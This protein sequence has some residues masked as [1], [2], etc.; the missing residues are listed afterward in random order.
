MT[1]RPFFVFNV[2]IAALTFGLFFGVTPTLRAET[3][4]PASSATAA[5][6]S[7][8]QALVT[9]EVTF[10]AYDFSQPWNDPTR[11]I[12]KH[13]VATGP[14]EL[15]TTAQ[16]LSTQTLVRLQR[17][18]RG[19]WVNARVTWIDLQANLALITCDDAAFW[20]GIT[21]VS[22]AEIVPPG[23]DFSLVSWR[24]GN[25]ETK[26]VEFSKF[27]V[28]TGRLGLAGQLTLEIDSDLP[29]LGWTELLVRDGQ[30]MG[31]TSWAG[32]R[33][34]GVIPAPFIRQVLAARR[35][36][37]YFDFT[38]QTAENPDLAKELKLPGDPRGVIATVPLRKTPQV[39][40]LRERDLILEIDGFTIGAEGDYHDP[41]Y[42]YL[43]LE[44]L[45]TRGHFAGDVIPIKVWREGRELTVEHTL[46]AA[47]YDEELIPRDT[48][49][50][51]RYLIAGGL[52]FQPLEQ[53]YLRAWGDDWRKN[54]PY[55]LQHYQYTEATA[56]R[57]SLIVLGSILPDPINLGYQN[58][59]RLVVDKVNGRTI[60]TLAEL[61]TA[62]ET[63]S[64]GGVHRIEFMRGAN[65]Q[66]MLIDA[67]TLDTATARVLE[68]YGIAAARRL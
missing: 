37:G 32:K 56:A 1:F 27:T 33:T 58:D 40:G 10:K 60:S 3:V 20:Q 57:P 31:L 2:S 41:H 8:D 54:A 35:A 14:R 13:A 46:S 18:G 23:P 24:D 11:S 52:V 47:T 48:P 59:A 22:L 12:R 28:S 16:Y 39:N 9:V 42:G 19:R 15:V 34:A 67:A 4:T 53:A 50:A 5:S 63:P 64:T 66:R 65:L 49:V 29:S 36:L 43:N 68:K 7:W 62:L 17:G 25:L 26:R 30:M 51:P 6:P 45:A 38:W 44:A 55:R 21:P 61:A